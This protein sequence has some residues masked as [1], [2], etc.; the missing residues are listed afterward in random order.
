MKP[1]AYLKREKRRWFDTLTVDHCFLIPDVALLILLPLW[2]G[3]GLNP[4]RNRKVQRRF[5]MYTMKVMRSDSVIR[6]ESIKVRVCT[7]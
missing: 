1:I 3:Q 4:D 6:T 5:L 2:V 7:V